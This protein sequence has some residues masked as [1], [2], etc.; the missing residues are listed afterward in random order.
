MQVIEPTS[1]GWYRDPFGRYERR[2][3]TGTGWTEHVKDRG[4]AAID[5]PHTHVPEA[6]VPLRIPA[7][8]HPA[9]SAPTPASPRSTV[10][11]ADAPLT[12]RDWPPVPELRPSAGGTATRA[13][14][15]RRRWRG[16][17]FGLIAVLGI[18]IGIAAGLALT[19][20]GSSGSPRP[21]VT[22]VRAADRVT[23][24][25]YQSV[26]VGASRTR[27]LQLVGH[28][29]VP[30]AEL[31]RAFPGAKVDHSCIYYY[32]PAPSTSYA[33]CFGRNGALATKSVRSR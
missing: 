6:G 28:Q 18:G 17:G 11:L 26:P 16:L 19:D 30:R 9:G 31:A 32:G 13:R 12:A 3:H 23:A 33:F 29:P 8:L 27:V 21:R 4:R 25:A 22:P 20:G 14:A 24:A 15:R 1:A 5:P 7:P 10:A 2:Y